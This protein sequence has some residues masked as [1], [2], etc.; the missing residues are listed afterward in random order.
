MEN[1]D[2]IKRPILPQWSPNPPAIPS[3]YP[4]ENTA[5]QCSTGTAPH[6]VRL[7][8][9]TTGATGQLQPPKEKPEIP[10]RVDAPQI[11][12]NG[13]AAK[14]AVPAAVT[15]RFKTDPYV[16]TVPIYTKEISSSPARYCCN[17]Y[18]SPESM[19][20]AATN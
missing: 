11:S 16:T 17:V 6:D 15:A 18:R 19:T 1:I 20:Q 2:G 10:K 13:W 3:N 7:Y 4:E 14:S 9:C 5:H 12:A 8:K